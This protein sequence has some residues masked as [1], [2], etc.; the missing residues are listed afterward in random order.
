MCECVAFYSNLPKWYNWLCRSPIAVQTTRLESEFAAFRT[1]ISATHEST[2]EITQTC[3]KSL[4][5]LANEVNTE[6]QKHEARLLGCE[7]GV[8]HFKSR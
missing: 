2:K 1:A 8:T 6:L 4:L 7:N 5:A 3:S